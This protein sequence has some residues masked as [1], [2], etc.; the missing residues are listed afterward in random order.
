MAFN[1]NGRFRQ[2]EM[3]PFEATNMTAPI[4][5]ATTPPTK[6]SAKTP[7]SPNESPT[8][9]TQPHTP[10]KYSLLG[11]KI[12]ATD[13]A[14]AVAMIIRAAVERRPL[15]VSALAV[16]GVM[17]G[18]LDPEH[19]HRLNQ[20]E[21]VLPDGQPVRWGLNW[22]HRARLAD[23][24][25][26]PNLMLATCAAAAEQ[27]LPIALY[28][29]KPE[30]LERLQTRL[31]QKFPNLKIAVAIPSLFRRL[32][33]DEKAPLVE[34]LQS[35]GARIVCV[36]LGCPRQEVWAYEFKDALRMPVLA[37]GAA[38]NVHAGELSQAPAWMQRI[39]LEWFYRLAMEPRRLWQRYLLLNP[40]YLWLL[41]LQATGL[42]RLDPDTAPAPQ[43]EILYG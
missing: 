40:Y 41:G 26:G 32:H 8:Q 34:R 20:L 16:H 18:V 17:T 23:R 22:L 4:E 5:I 2:I 42:Y 43:Q 37:V 13:Y 29:G 14:G 12:T 33:A 30:L 31:L 35:S 28:G 36:G 9:P 10:P 19:R 39:G 7:F 6:T 27:G 21:L 25:Y 24:V 15:G 11:V 3:H 38:F 1:E